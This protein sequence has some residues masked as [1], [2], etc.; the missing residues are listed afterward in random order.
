M[1]ATCHRT[2]GYAKVFF[3]RHRL[4]I[5]G[6]FI[7]V[8]VKDKMGIGLSTS[9]RHYWKSPDTSPD[10][11]EDPTFSPDYGFAAKRKTRS[12][13]MSLLPSVL[14]VKGHRQRISTVGYKT[15]F[16]KFNIEETFLPFT[17]I[18]NKAVSYTHLTLPTIYS[19]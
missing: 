4:N 9:Y 14:V 7:F 13:Y 12:A 16:R 3:G 15:I 2:I 11:F 1:A 5:L 18:T 10:V 6:L 8:I 19:V 17:V